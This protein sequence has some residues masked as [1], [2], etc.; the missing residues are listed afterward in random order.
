ML[1]EERS[2]VICQ[3]KWLCL[4]AHTFHAS[5][6]LA[7]SWISSRTRCSDGSHRFA[8]AE[9]LDRAEA[10][11][12]CGAEIDSLEAKWLSEVKLTTFDEGEISFRAGLFSFLTLTRFGY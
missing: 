6:H 11:G 2:V 7:S 8:L 5:W 9:V 3:G 12:R 4:P 10:E 1:T